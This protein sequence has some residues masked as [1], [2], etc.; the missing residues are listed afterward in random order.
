[1]LTRKIL[2]VSLLLFIVIGIVLAFAYKSGNIYPNPEPSADSVEIPEL[3]EGDLV[4]RKGRSLVSRVVLMNDRGSA[5]SHVGIVAFKDGEPLIVHAVTGEPDE[6]G[7]EK[8]KCDTPTDF[9]DAEKASLFAVF[10]LAEDEKH[11]A[12]MAAQKAMAY[13]TMGLP[14]DKSFDFRSED[15]LYCTELVW[16]AYLAAGVNLTGNNFHV[17]TLNFLADS[18]ILPGQFIESKWLTQ[19]YP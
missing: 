6:S 13:Y 14:F 9:L 7:D 17:L 19:I 12:K 1:M 5:Y 8:V 4:F 10:R 16:K 18:I 2:P 3:C 11:L 15:K